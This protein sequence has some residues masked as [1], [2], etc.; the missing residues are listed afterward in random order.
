MKQK[1][2][3]QKAQRIFND[4]NKILFKYAS[5]DTIVYNQISME[6]L[7]KDYKWNDPS[8]NNAENNPQFFELKNFRIF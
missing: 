4:C 6:N 1:V 2:K 5:I 8:L 7:L 3:D